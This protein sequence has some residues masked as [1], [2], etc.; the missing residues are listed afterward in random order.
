MLKTVL[1][2]TLFSR[3]KR[4]IAGNWKSNKTQQEAVDF[5]KNTIHGLKYNPNN[6]GNIQIIKMLSSP[7][8]IYTYRRFWHSI[9]LSAYLTELQLKMLR[10]SDSEHLPEKSVRNIWRTLDLIG[11]FS[12]IPRG[13]LFS[14]KSTISL[15][16]RLSLPYRMVWKWFIVSGRRKTVQKVINSERQANKTW[17][18]LKTQL[19]P[20]VE[21]MRLT[22]EHWMENI[23]L[24]YEPVWAIG[25]GINSS[26]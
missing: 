25:T 26:P 17:D 7:L 13:G 14:E 11:W 6:V 5:V 1:S 8:S 24:A 10:I 16:L 4:M 3:N 19:T 18:V 12:V 23:V 15:F 2:G 20:L 21:A 22:P 9:P